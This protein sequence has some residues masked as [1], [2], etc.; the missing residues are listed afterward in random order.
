MAEI[1]PKCFAVLVAALLLPLMSRAA[2]TKLDSSSLAET[3]KGQTSVE[4][5]LQMLRSDDLETQITAANVAAKH[6][7]W[8]QV[9]DEP[10]RK[11]AFDARQPNALRVAAVAA[12]APR[13][14]PVDMHL[15]E[16]VRSNLTAENP[17]MLKHFLCA[18]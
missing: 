11:I 18:Y 10:L 1:V 7:D 4:Q 12:L 8:S 13:L 2:E 17:P 6:A 15:F 14:F 3:N 5:I 9:L 16:L